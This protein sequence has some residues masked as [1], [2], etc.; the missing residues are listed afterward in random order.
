MW[1]REHLLRAVSAAPLMRREHL[2]VPP[3]PP[4][5]QEIVDAVISSSTSQ[6]V[7]TSDMR[8]VPLS[9]HDV[10]NMCLPTVFE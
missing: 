7:S 2:I 3:S 10:W 9:T 8:E 4:N 5:S 6:F 1:S